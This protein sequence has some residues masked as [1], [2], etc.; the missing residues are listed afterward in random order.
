MNKVTLSIVV[1]F[2]VL[3]LG[4][5]LWHDVSKAPEVPVTPTQ[6][7]ISSPIEVFSPRSGET[8]SSP[9]K[10]TGRARGSWF[11]EASFPVELVGSD[12]KIIA[13][14]PA[15]AK[16][17]WMTSDFVP[18]EATL[19]F[20]INTECVNMKT[21]KSPA[22]L[23]LKKDNPSDMRQY[24]ASISIPIFIAP[25]PV[26]TPTSTASGKCFISGCSREICSDKEGVMSICIYQ[27]QFAC[28]K[29]ATCE[30]Q[31][32]GGCGWTQTAALQACL[33]TNSSAK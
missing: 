20:A 28:Y 21:C 9:I 31:S 10:I 30:R 8:V 4:V 3:I 2:I 26:F 23:V 15:Q 27:P 13:Q 12:G 5:V 29:A 19:N 32:N 1:G 6:N 33:S 25:R 14:A 18:F 24:D 22:I 16:G 11:F 7:A 17:D